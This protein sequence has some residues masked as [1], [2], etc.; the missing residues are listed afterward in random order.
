ME[1]RTE[2]RSE[3]TFSLVRED[4]Q[5]SMQ[6]QMQP[7]SFESAQYDI[8]LRHQRVRGAGDVKSTAI[9]S[10]FLHMS[11]A[12]EFS[13][14]GTLSR[15]DLAPDDI[16]KGEQ[17]VARASAAGN[18]GQFVASA[19]AG[20]AVLGSVFYALPAVVVASGI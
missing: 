9:P 7:P 3:R 11:N 4:T 20:N 17:D 6:I 2:T 15:L 16:R 13:G 14:W 5:P 8:V 19:L 1:T 18:L 12:F 10:R